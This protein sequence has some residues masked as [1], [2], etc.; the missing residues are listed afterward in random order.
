M[1]MKGIELDEIDDDYTPV[2]M[3]TPTAGAPVQPSREAILGEAVD[4]AAMIW[5]LTHPSPAAIRHCV[6]I[7]AGSY[8]GMDFMRLVRDFLA[9]LSSVADFDALE[10]QAR[11]HAGK[12]DGGE[13]FIG[14]AEDDHIQVAARLIAWDVV[15]ADDRGDTSQAMIGRLAE[16]VGL[17]EDVSELA[18]FRLLRASQKMADWGYIDAIITEPALDSRVVH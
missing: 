8:T 17:A 7:E 11:Q 4:T 3:P 14:G 12:D 2:P 10:N 1:N 13:G 6:C 18:R 9:E 5:A 16:L 15:C